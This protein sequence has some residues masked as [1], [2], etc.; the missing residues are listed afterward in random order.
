MILYSL[1]ELKYLTDKFYN[2]IRLKRSCL[3]GKINFARFSNNE[4]QGRVF[5]NTR[6]Q[7]CLLIGL[8][9][10]PD[11]ALLRTFILSHTLKKEGAHKISAIFPYLAYTR[12][13]K[14]EQYLSYITDWIGKVTVVSGIN[15]IITIDFHSQIAKKLIKIPIVNLSSASLF[16][17]KMTKADLEG[18]VV[19]APDEGAKERANL[20]RKA[21]G[22]SQPIAYFKKIR[23]R[24]NITSVELIGQI[25]K[26]IILVDDVLDT[27]G[28][29]ISCAKELKKLGVKKITV[30]VTHGL[31]T[32]EKW[33][34]LF[35]LNVTKIIT[36]DSVPDVLKMKDKRIK[37]ASCA[38]LLAETFK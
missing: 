36:T 3:K 19:V 32:N 10:P 29:L 25:S 21:A 23:Q 34:E 35:K 13:D 9:T 31:F 2:L 17:S 5:E 4:W 12:H 24:E 37:V 33:K 6:G 27:G 30:A 22:I 20:F 38:P 1:P 18:A 16:L 28:T 26:N 7:D 8:I 15:K 11:D 14:K